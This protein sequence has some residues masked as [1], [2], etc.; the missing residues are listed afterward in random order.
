M[1][2]MSLDLYDKTNKKEEVN[3]CELWE[4]KSPHNTR[5]ITATMGQPVAHQSLWNGPFWIS[6]GLHDFH[7]LASSFPSFLLFFIFCVQYFLFQYNLKILQTKILSLLSLLSLFCLFVLKF[8]SREREGEANLVSTS[9][10]HLHVII[11]NHLL[12]PSTCNTF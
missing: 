7:L 8:P 10:S 12:L 9:V 5:S 4:P 11:I 1:H 6:P 3:Y 2:I